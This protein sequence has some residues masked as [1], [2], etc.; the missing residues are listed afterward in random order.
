MSA[1]IKILL[2]PE[3]QKIAR[4]LQ[5]LPDRAL[6]AIAAAMYKENQLTVA[7]IKSKYLSFPRGG[8][9]S[10]IGLRKRSTPGY[11]STLW[12]P[13]PEILGQTITSSI[14]SPMKS[15]GVSYP[16]V[17]EFGADIPSRPTRSK[18]KYYRKK[19]PQ[20]KA[21]SIGARAPVQHGISGRITNYTASVSAA[22][23][24]AC[25]NPESE[26]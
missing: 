5:T 25:K 4:D 19:H 17:H 2:T 8:P 3:A 6:K 11:E 14:G 12:S 22:L 16:A 10:P 1:T 20:T 21:Y 13:K 9:V 23:I 7:E 18:N 26:K 15:R 24:A